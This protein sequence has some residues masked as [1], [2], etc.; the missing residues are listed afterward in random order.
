MH[1]FRR[2][3]TE[4]AKAA[5]VDAKPAET[6]KIQTLDPSNAGAL[7]FELSGPI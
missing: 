6:A 1:A 3:L 4:D 2:R 7:S 5:E